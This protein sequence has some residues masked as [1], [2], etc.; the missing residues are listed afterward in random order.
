MSAELQAI[1]WEDVPL[2]EVNESMRRRIVT[3]KK[4]TVA[5]IYFTDGFVVPMHSHHN[6]QITQVIKGQML[7]V[8]A[9]DEPKELLLNPGDVV[10]I[11]AHVPHQATC[12]GAVEEIDMWAPRRDDWLDGSDDYLRTSS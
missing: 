1:N 8:F 4:M 3:G 6:E 10:V 7:F 2:K 12:I 11:P 5:K 9:G